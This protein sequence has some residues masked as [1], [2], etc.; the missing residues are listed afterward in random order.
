M[1]EGDQQGAQQMLPG[2]V[3]RRAPRLLVIGAH[4]DHP[5]RDLFTTSVAR[6]ALR[7]CPVPVFVG[8]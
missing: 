6:A 1:L 8:A 7:D 3:R 2:E 5:V 4:G